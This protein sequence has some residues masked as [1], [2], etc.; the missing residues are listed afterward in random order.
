MPTAFLT[1]G[2]GF[3]G[4]HVA[5]ALVSD[6]WTVRLLTRDPA[7]AGS[8][9]LAGLPLEFVPG[10]LSE[11]GLAGA[12]LEGVEAIVH[13]AGLINARSLEEYREVNVRGTERLLDAAR[14]RAPRALFVLVSSQAAAG[15]AID[16]RPVSDAD[17]ARPVSR[18]GLSKREG[19]E[20]VATGWPGP[21]HVIR[22]GIVYG[23]GDRGLLQYF[24]MAARG[25][26]PIPA[27]NTR[28]QIV[29]GA[30][31]G[32][33]IARAAGRFD[34]SERRSFLCDSEPVTIGALA[35][36][37]GAGA[38]RPVR[39]LPVPDLVVRG[40]GFLE[41]AREA[42]TRQA[43]SFNGDKAR[44]ILAGDWLCDGRRLASTLALPEPI[45]LAEG[46][47]EAWQWY[48]SAGWITVPGSF[49]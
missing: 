30:R 26:V 2:T 24:R 11:R 10:D 16:G 14:R 38:G 23:P 9:L 8:R 21:W 33:A 6:G 34:L 22:P 48:A 36:G 42:V 41:T 3:V 39:F 47:R 20:A 13:V 28:I 19:E 40:L 27:P 7:R 5:R 46:L 29:A 17:A 1:G 43:R 49:L 25:W 44:E 37:I 4:G 45:P 31:A 18:Y 15:P 32:L 12:R 35:R